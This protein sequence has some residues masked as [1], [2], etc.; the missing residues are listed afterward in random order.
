MNDL[1][2]I[3]IEPEEIVSFL[4]RKMNLKEVYQEILFKRVIS[5]AAQQRGITVTTVEIEA[6]ADRQRREQRLEKATDTLA[7][8]SD[9][10]VTPHDWEMGI[11]DRLL[12][13]KLAHYM[14]AEKVEDFFIKN[15][16]E[17]EQVILYQIIVESDKLAQEI[18][19]QIAEGEISFYHAANL[20]DID[21]H[22]RHKCGY[23][24]TIYRF[25]IQPDIAA[26]IFQTPPKQLIGPLKT[27]QGHHLL[28]VEELL[29]AELTPERYQEILHNM[30]HDWLVT[31]LDYMLNSS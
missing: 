30:F 29:P 15:S 23:E 26:M 8:L 19:Y 11:R 9:Q 4:K 7:W 10:L 12:S 17:F 20:Y 13:Q 25:D 6:E 14:F 31:E 24:G 21:D 18:Y 2:Q 16:L 27:E 28:I 22:R 5:Y 3:F 1:S